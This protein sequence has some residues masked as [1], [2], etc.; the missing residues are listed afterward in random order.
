MGESICGIYKITNDINNK[1]YIGQ[2]KNIKRRFS[3][4]KSEGYRKTHITKR[5]YKAIAKY[6]IE[7]FSFEIIEICNTI[8]LDEREKFWIDYFGSYGNG[9]NDTLGGQ[10]KHNCIHC[11]PKDF[12]VCITDTDKLIDYYCTDSSGNIYDK[13]DYNSPFDETVDNMSIEEIHNEYAG[14][15]T[16]TNDFS[17]GYDNFESWA[18]CNLI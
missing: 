1:C 7:N 2:S 18:E 6:G 4:H 10:G 5:L 12:Y 17:D 16:L 15:E 3:E 8:K 13:F 9:Y 11:M 14:Y